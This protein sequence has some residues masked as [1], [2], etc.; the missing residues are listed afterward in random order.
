MATSADYI[1]P[2][3]V[4]SSS[5]HHRQVVASFSDMQERSIMTDFNIELS[6][7]DLISV[8]RNVLYA[9]C[10]YFKALFTSGMK[11]DT[12]GKVRFETLSEA[13]V[14]GVI[15][16]LYGRKLSVDWDDVEE[17]L[18][19]VERFQLPKLKKKLE[20]Y[21]GQ[22]ICAQNCLSLY[23]LADRYGLQQLRIKTKESF[24]SH[25]NRWCTSD[26]FKQLSKTDVIN[27]FSDQALASVKN[28]IKLK[29]IIAWVTYEEQARK[30]CFP[31]LLEAI[32]LCKCSSS[33]LKYV[34]DTYE[35]RL[36]N[37]VSLAVKIAKAMASGVEAKEAVSVD[38]FLVI[39][40]ILDDRSLSKK[41]YVVDWMKESVE[42][43]GTVPDDLLRWYPARCF[44]PSGLFSGAGGTADDFA[45]A[46]CNCS[47]YDPIT[48][49]LTSLPS[50]PSPLVTA[51]AAC[52]KS[53]VYMIGG[54]GHFTQMISLDLNEGKQWLEC[55]DLKQGVVYPIVCSL[56][57]QIFILTSTLTEAGT[58]H[59][60]G[61]EIKLQCYNTE[62][63]DCSFR[64]SPPSGITDTDGVS[65]VPVGDDI[66]YV[67]G[68]DKLCLRYATKE[69]K[70][71]RHKK[72]LREHYYGGAVHVNGNIILYGGLSTDKMETYNIARDTWEISSIKLP[73]QLT[74]PY[75]IN[76]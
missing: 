12:E 18:N 51:G 33:Y 45:S 46:T 52:V 31:E 42:E 3:N 70:W 62:T 44:T 22:N 68:D 15:D 6:S 56:K 7:G 65:T 24:A 2:L 47:L 5:N 4:E 36:I 72:P 40:G 55:K 57:E 74:S 30:E 34:L 13:V 63:Q 21:I 16:Y 10:D 35:D 11:E 25:L 20:E 54:E 73:L 28:D 29:A 8:H 67:G 69:D 49:Q 41:I 71:Y 60:M 1:A 48:Q 58:Y 17:Y 66:Y 27:L 64:A 61:D 39:G 76:V 19:A 32:E 50:I 53:K 9:T 75:C 59:Y 37:K 23:Q 26:K 43:V 38:K 14:R